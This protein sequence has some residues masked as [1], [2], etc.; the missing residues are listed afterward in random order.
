MTNWGRVYY[1]NFLSAAALLMVFPFCNG[2]HEL[3]KNYNFTPPQIVLLALSCAI[4]VCM[5]HAGEQLAC[6]H[7]AAGPSRAACAHRLLHA[8]RPTRLVLLLTW[9]AVC[10]RCSCTG[11]LMRSNVSAT[12]GVVVG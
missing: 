10:W 11:Y 1:T 8:H 9:D 5:S 3:L 7:T 12:A 4:G 6:Q 2:E